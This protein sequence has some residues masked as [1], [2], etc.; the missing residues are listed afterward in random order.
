MNPQIGTVMHNPEIFPRPTHFDPNRFL[1]EDGKTIDKSRAEHLVP[2]GIG[3]RQC[4]GESLAK[5]ELFLILVSLL[6]RYVFTVPGG[7][8][9][10]DLTTDYGVTLAPKAY[11]CTVAL[12]N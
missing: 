7:A 1:A 9:T 10:P 5:M 6:Q 11:K 8:A 2:F 3:K 4:A 12:R